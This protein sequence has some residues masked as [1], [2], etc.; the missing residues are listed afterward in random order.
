M[1]LALPLTAAGRTQPLVT[2]RRPLRLLAMCALAL[3]LGGRVERVV[4]EPLGSSVPPHCEAHTSFSGGVDLADDYRCAGLAI[5]FHAAGPWASPFPIWAGQWLFV[6]ELGQFRVG[7]CTFNRGI[8]PSIAAP[9]AP[10]EQRFPNDPSGAKSAYLTWRYGDTTDDVTAA[11][12]WA[13]FH[14]YAQDAAGTNRNPNGSAPLVPRL[15]RIGEQSGRDDLEA[16][17]L[18]LDGEASRFVDPFTL[19]LTLGADG[20]LTTTVRSGT[21]AVPD[22]AVLLG[23]GSTITTGADGSVRHAISLSAGHTTITGSAARPGGAVVYRGRPAGSD[24]HGAQTLVTGGTPGRM[25]A[26]VSV[27]IPSPTTTSVAETTSTQATTTTEAPTTGSIATTSTS[28]SSV[29]TTSTSTST[30]TS[31]TTTTTVSQTTTS[32]TIATTTTL[33][34]S[35]TTATTSATTSAVAATTMAPSLS[36]AATPTT[37]VPTTSAPAAAR[38]LPRTGSEAEHMAAY[39]GVALL[40]AGIGLLGAIGRRATA[41]DP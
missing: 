18:R 9:S 21:S 8:H 23:D 38:R 27:D 37:A 41:A 7:S 35:T 1:P 4:A 30:S 20:I 12:L 31:S 5:D 10:V 13:V 11:A 25:T 6:D 36:A 39:V 34:T 14:Y 32:T 24:P 26:E 22:V 19:D 3:A 29:A 33:P 40:V 28:T 2:H 15:D 17:A 16:L